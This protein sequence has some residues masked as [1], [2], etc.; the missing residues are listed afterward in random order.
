MT[1]PLYERRLEVHAQQRLKRNI[2]ALRLLR[3]LPTQV[4][5]FTS[6]ASELLLIG[7]NRSS[8]TFLLALLAASAMTG[9][10]ITD[11]EGN[12]YFPFPRNRPLYI[13]LIGLGEEH[14]A[15]TWYNYLFK[16]KNELKAIRDLESGRWRA[17]DARRE[18]DRQRVKHFEA[19]DNSVGVRIMPP[20]I[21]K[22]LIKPRSPGESG[23]IAFKNKAI[24]FF[25]GLEM[26]PRAEFGPDCTQGTTVRTYTSIADAKRGDAVDAIFIDEK[27]AHWQHYTEW[28]ARLSD[29]KGRIFWAV[30]PDE[31]ERPNPALMGLIERCEADQTM[32]KPDAQ[33]VRLIFED[34]PYIDEDEKRKKRKQFDDV[35]WA[36]R[37]AGIINTSNYLVYPHFSTKLH[38]C[39]AFKEEHDDPLDALIRQRASE[40]PP[41]WCI[42]LI[43]D[44]GRQHPGVLFVATPPPKIKL[45]DHDYDSGGVSLVCDELYL[46]Q[47][48]PSMLARKVAEKMRG[49]AIHRFI[50]DYRAGVQEQMGAMMGHT[51]SYLYSEAFRKEGLACE[52]TNFEFQFSSS[53]KRADITL[54]SEALHLGQAGRPRLRYVAMRCPNFAKQMS[55][56]HKGQDKQGFITDDPAARQIDP[57]CDCVRYFVASAPKYVEPR[58]LAQKGSEPYLL[59]KE[60]QAERKA[61]LG[62]AVYCGAG[63]P[64]ESQLFT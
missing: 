12:E 26:L 40:V 64:R 18:D 50:I 29:R 5:A 54:V 7:G 2:E 36:A 48:D 27:I 60:L 41:D 37:N 45:D 10:P 33:M 49:R 25:K 6:L 3:L 39:P 58:S 11:W 23:G 42:D 63:V 44:P 24:G 31:F 20:L 32:A 35:S 8:K 34:N 57:L 21:P 55:K 61:K 30:T 59:W 53:S 56:Y 47:H 19:G 17:Y 1:Q 4:P 13:W 16:Q 62:N 14:I 22:R 51:V 28:L 52:A 9:I 46:P 15:T 43:L 38:C